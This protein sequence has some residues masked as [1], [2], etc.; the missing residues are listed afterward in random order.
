[1]ACQCTPWSCSDQLVDVAAEAQ[2]GTAE[3]WLRLISSR[4]VPGHPEGLPTALAGAF[5]MDGNKPEHLI[6]PFGSGFDA[7]TRRAVLRTYAP[8]VWASSGPTTLLNQ[9]RICCIYDFQF[10][11]SWDSAVIDPWILGCCRLP[12][13]CAYFTMVRHENDP[14]VWHRPSALCCGAANHSYLLRRVAYR[15]TQSG[16]WV[17]TPHLQSFAS[18]MKEK[19]QPRGSRVQVYAPSVAQV[20]PSGPPDESV[21]MER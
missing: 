6:V 17:A 15:D 7:A 20:T 8:G 14:D 18:F 12:R 16:E 21:S 9:K 3:D 13:C 4:M 1:M 2:A 11:E 10:N 5:W 19:A